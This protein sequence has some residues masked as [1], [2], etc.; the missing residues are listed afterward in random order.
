VPVGKRQ[1]GHGASVAGANSA[2]NGAVVGSEVRLA[3]LSTTVERFDCPIKLS[4]AKVSG[5]LVK[6]FWPFMVGDWLGHVQDLQVAN[7]HSLLHFEGF[8]SRNDG[9]RVSRGDYSP[10]TKQLVDVFAQGMKGTIVWCRL[11]SEKPSSMREADSN[12]TCR[13]SQNRYLELVAPTRLL[14]LLPVRSGAQRHA[15]ALLRRAS[16]RLARPSKFILAGIKLTQ[17]NV[18]GGIA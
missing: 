8:A 9:D 13:A 15:S 10:R 18:D 5:H 7:K 6:R 4:E 16:L 1:S 11:H 2:D 14:H 17:A 12:Q 3:R